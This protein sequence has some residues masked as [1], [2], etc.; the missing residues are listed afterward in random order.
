MK[1]LK[2]YEQLT[3]KNINDLGEYLVIESDDINKRMDDNE[4][5]IVKLLMLGT[6]EIKL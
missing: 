2:T 5:F 3:S 4:F 1:Y 6:S